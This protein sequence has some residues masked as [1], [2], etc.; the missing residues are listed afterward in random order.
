MP[1]ANFIL[2]DWIK[3][4]TVFL[5]NLE[6]LKKQEK[7]ETV[8]LVHDLRVAI[9]KLRAYLKL[10]GVLLGKKGNTNLFQKT[11]DL[12]NVLGK[13]RDIEMA[14]EGLKPVLPQSLNVHIHT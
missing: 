7:A 11:E 1:A 5:Q 12:F 4:Q 8:D 14:L 9:K 13:H 3:Q 2:K 10:L 6:E